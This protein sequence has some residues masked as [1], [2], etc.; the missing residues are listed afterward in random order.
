MKIKVS[1]SKFGVSSMALWILDCVQPCGRI[2][3]FSHR[4]VLL[5]ASCFLLLVPCAFAQQFSIGWGKMAASSGVSTGGVYSISGTI[6][7]AVAST[8]SSDNQV[9]ESS[10]W[11]IMGGVQTL[12]VPLLAITAA[13]HLLDGDLQL[14][15]SGNVDQTYTL[16][17]S[18]NLED[19]VTVLTFTCTNSPMYLADPEA[20]TYPHRFYRIVQ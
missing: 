6:G 9:L 5:L 11:G 20:G 13:G 1:S 2:A 19:W 10:Y 3:D 12:G 8:V 14:E 15:F 4:S 18:T 16:Q 17:A 7:Q